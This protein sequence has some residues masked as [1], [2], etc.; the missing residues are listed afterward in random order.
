MFLLLDIPESCIYWAHIFFK[1][2]FSIK[3]NPNLHCIFYWWS[4]V[5]FSW[6]G[7]SLRQ[8]SQMRPVK[9]CSRCFCRGN[10]TCGPNIDIPD[11]CCN[12][13]CLQ[14]NV[15]TFSV[16]VQTC[17]CATKETPHKLQWAMLLYFLSNLKGVTPLVTPSYSNWITIIR[18]F[19][20][21]CVESWMSGYSS[22]MI[23]FLSHWYRGKWLIVINSNTRSTKL[24]I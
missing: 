10:I 13:E 14:V 4:S 16:W 3:W 21:K 6:V 2:L 9:H 12:G 19:E 5:S 8:Y 7:V 20:R 15:K 22:T 17:V 23:Y 1:L 11:T 24:L 18:V